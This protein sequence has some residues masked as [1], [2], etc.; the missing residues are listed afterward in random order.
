METIDTM[1]YIV[2]TRKNG[3]EIWVTNDNWNLFIGECYEDTPDETIVDVMKKATVIC[4]A[5]NKD[6]MEK[7]Q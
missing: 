6:Q 5:L 7:I 1:P 2:T 3:C 4:N